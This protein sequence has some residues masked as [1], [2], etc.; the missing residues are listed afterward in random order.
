M[1]VRADDLG[2]RNRINP[3]GREIGRELACCWPELIPG[4]GVDEDEFLSRS[5]Q[6]DVGSGLDIVQSPAKAPDDLF[7]FLRGGLR[8]DD[9][10]WQGQEAVT[11]DDDVE[12]ALLERG[13]LSRGCVAGQEGHRS[14]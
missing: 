2:Y 12:H 14:K 13:Y 7:L 11:D 10:D 1:G 3:C 4:I 6:R 9:V 5:D 8:C